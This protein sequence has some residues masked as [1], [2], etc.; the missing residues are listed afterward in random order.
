MDLEDDAHMVANEVINV[1]ITISPEIY[2]QIADLV[3]QE[4]SKN[5][6]FLKELV[7]YQIE[8]WMDHY[9]D[10]NDH[11]KNLDTEQLT[12]NVC[13]EVIEVIKMRL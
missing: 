7:Q 9:F 4:I 13:D 11:I 8:D 6:K 3:V 10:I 1:P 5:P 12:G 2:K